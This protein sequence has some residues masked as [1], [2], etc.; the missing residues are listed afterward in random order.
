V[1]RLL[2][3][4][5]EGLEP[6]VDAGGPAVVALPGED[7]ALFRL[8]LE[9]TGRR[10]RADEL[11]MKV[12]DL[13]AEDP[14]ALHMAV[15]RPDAEGRLWVALMDPGRLEAR[16]D[17][18]DKA[19]L[20]P[21]AVVPAALLLPEPEPGAVS[22]AAAGTKVLVRGE[23]LAAC[24]ERDL[25][26]HLAAG[27]R[28]APPRPLAEALRERVPLPGDLSLDLR[29]GRFAPPV[30][31]WRSRAFQA[32]IGLLLALAAGLAALPAVWAHLRASR[33]ADAYDAATLAIAE[34][35]LGARPETAVAAAQALADAR[36]QAEG[37][38]VAPRL[39]FAVATLE[40]H[41][42]VLLETVLLEAGGPLALGLSG[43]AGAVNAAAAALAAGP[44][45][46]VQEGTTVR[47]G[48]ARRPAGSPATPEA[49]RAAEARMLAARRDALA[50]A[51]GRPAAGEAPFAARIS[52]RLA[53]A[54]LELVPEAQPGGLLAVSV[55]AVRSAVLLP[56]LADFEL[57]GATLTELRIARN[58]DRTLR[59]SLSLKE[60]P[61]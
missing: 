56:L 55:P 7:I 51:A 49:A 2:L 21:E 35:A 30:R 32:G 33:L 43:E 54:G 45:E 57:D 39:S 31:W 44:F 13:A 8:R 3:A 6:V 14:A 61:R 27:A 11:A 38:A 5:A 10:A 26:A 36:R 29:Q 42:R 53:R 37:A 20:S 46:S 59:A 22:T 58:S 4:G 41:P 24:V 25:V 1:T 34:R 12:A 40:R 48:A 28:V 60:T 52:G 9:A 18:L 19:G 15:S 23:T 50:L 17:A 47:L 16:L